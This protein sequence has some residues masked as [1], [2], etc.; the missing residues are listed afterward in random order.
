MYMYIYMYVN[1]IP[2]GYPSIFILFFCAD[3]P[4]VAL[5]I[6]PVI[7]I[8]KHIAIVIQSVVVREWFML[9]SN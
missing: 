4:P 5:P 2:S 6:P 9:P 8:V 3:L 1:S 7:S